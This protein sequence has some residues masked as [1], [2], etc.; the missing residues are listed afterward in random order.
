[1]LPRRLTHPSNGNGAPLT[2]ASA[3][4]HQRV[5]VVAVAGRA[6]VIQRLAALGIVPGVSM[7]VLRPNEPTV[8]SVGSAKIAVGS[9]AA[10]SVEIEVEE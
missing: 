8:V 1:M 3:Q 7:T 10:R 9:G 6:S 4:R 5:R 2:L